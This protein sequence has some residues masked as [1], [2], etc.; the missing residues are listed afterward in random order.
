VQPAS[1]N[2]SEVELLYREHGSALLLCA[3]AICAEHSRAEDAVH[4]VFFRIIDRKALL[5]AENPKAYLFACVRNTLL[6]DRKSRERDVTLDENIRWFEPPDRDY[7]AE[8]N[9]RLALQGLPD[10]QRQII[11]LHVWGELTFSEIAGVLNINA[12]TAASRYRYALGKLREAMCGKE[13]TN[14]SAR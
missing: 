5:K 6:N 11:V 3:L 12:N 9:L 8:S 4:Q 7:V 14:G 13:I 10:E 1:Q 2:A